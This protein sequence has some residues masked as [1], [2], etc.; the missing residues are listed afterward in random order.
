LRS[1]LHVLDVLAALVDV[2]ERRE[3][4]IR[5]LGSKLPTGRRERRI[6]RDWTRDLQRPRPAGDILELIELAVVIERR[7]GG[8]DAC[9]DLE[10]F[11][12]LGVAIL[13]QLQPEHREFLRIPSAKDV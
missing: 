5:R 13:A 8:V 1:L 6:E 4:K 9:D 3:Q 11:K 2:D 10:P 7:V 12:S